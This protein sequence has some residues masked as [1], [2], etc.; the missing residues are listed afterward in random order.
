MK[1][2]ALAAAV[3]V[4]LAGTAHAAVTEFVIYKQ[5]DFKGASQT[6]KGEVNNLEGGFARE[7]SS[8]IVRGGHWEV[9]NQDHF[10][11]ECRVIPPGEY[12]RLGPGLDE[13][14]VSVRFVG[15]DPKVARSEDRREARETRDARD[16]R[17][18]RREP[19][20]DAR[21]AQ[22]VVDLYGRPD[23]GCRSLRVNDNM[24]SL[25][26]FDGRASSMIVHEGTWQLC[27][28][29]RFE[30]RC[31]VFTPGEYSRLAGLDDRVSSLRQVR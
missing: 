15:I 10:Q 25:G 1:R 29:P 5:P 30:G 2:T 3:A 19:R 14:I 8:L 16:A 24:P 21:R 20:R 12:P 23:F 6:V 31:S 27:T 13:R 17:E 7:G 11:G 18:A 28:E 9:C 22:G 26:E 4:L